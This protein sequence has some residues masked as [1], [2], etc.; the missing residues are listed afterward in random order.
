MTAKTTSPLNTKLFAGCH[1]N[2]ELR[3]YLN[4]S[5]QWKHA[6]I[7]TPSAERTWQEIH[8]HGKDYFGLYIDS[9]KVSVKDLTAIQQNIRESLKNYCPDVEAENIKVCIFPQVFIA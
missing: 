9:K 2:S 1:I 5:I 6:M 4:Q 8:Y 3:M 7:L